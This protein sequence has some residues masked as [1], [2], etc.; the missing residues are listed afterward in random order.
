[1]GTCRRFQQHSQT[2]EGASVCPLTTCEFYYKKFAYMKIWAKIFMKVCVLL[3]PRPHPLNGSVLCEKTLCL[4]SFCRV[5]DR[6]S[7][8]MICS[9]TSVSF[10]CLW[11]SAFL[12]GVPFSSSYWFCQRFG[13]CR[14]CAPMKVETKTYGLSLETH[15]LPLRS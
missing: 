11:L 4:L 15:P 10:G 13:E 3:V 6:G 8:L 12:C 7:D 9:L 1:M 2:S 14:I 5:K